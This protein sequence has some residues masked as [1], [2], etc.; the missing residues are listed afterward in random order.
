MSSLAHG[1]PGGIEGQGDAGPD[2]GLGLL[3]SGSDY[4]FLIHM[5]GVA[6]SMVSTAH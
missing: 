2:A 4:S 6:I 3:L 1:L 5:P